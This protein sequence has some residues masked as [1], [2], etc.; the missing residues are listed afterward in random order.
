MENWVVEL[1]D[2]VAAPGVQE[3]APEPFDYNLYQL[4]HPLRWVEAQSVLKGFKRIWLAYTSLSSELPYLVP[5]EASRL[6]IV[7]S[8]NFRTWR[9]FNRMCGVWTKQCRPHRISE[10]RSRKQKQMLKSSQSLL[11]SLRLGCDIVRRVTV[12][13]AVKTTSSKTTR[14]VYTKSWLL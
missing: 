10:Y 6:R 5:S 8:W 2:P 14:T 12:S 13:S 9:W 4:V 1:V 11:I 3:Q 7:Q